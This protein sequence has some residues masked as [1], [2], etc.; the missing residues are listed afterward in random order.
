MVFLNIHKNKMSFKDNFE[1]KKFYIK[2]SQYINT[3]KTPTQ[4]SKRIVGMVQK[5]NK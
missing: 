2:C 1:R 4:C 3:N 5:Y